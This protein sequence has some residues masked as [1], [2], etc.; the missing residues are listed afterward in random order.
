MQ[1]IIRYWGPDNHE[2]V[3]SYDCKKVQIKNKTVIID[4]ETIIPFKDI[5]EIGGVKFAYILDNGPKEY[6]VNRDYA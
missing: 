5:D 3:E 6:L 2:D 4:E 1:L